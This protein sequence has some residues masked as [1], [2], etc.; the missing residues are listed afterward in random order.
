M[1]ILPLPPTPL[2][3]NPAWYILQRQWDLQELHNIKEIVN[4]RFIYEGPNNPVG[5]KID[6]NDWAG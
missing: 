5:G 4:I 2:G 1:I 6:E 3:L